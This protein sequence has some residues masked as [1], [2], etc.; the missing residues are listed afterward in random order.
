MKS[1]I[2]N[3]RGRLT[4][5]G[6]TSLAIVAISVGTMMS[7]ALFTDDAMLE[8]N[9]FTAGTIELSTTPASALFSVTSMMPGDVSYGQLTVSN[10]GSAELRYSMTSSSTDPDTKA[11]AAALNVEIRE[12]AAGTCSADFTGAVVLAST[13]LS[14]AAFGDA[15]AGQDTGDRV[16]A[17]STS[18]DV[19]F[20]VS[21]PG[22]AGDS[23][24][25]ATTTTTF[26][27]QAEQTANNS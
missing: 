13:P 27:F 21:L 9:T 2:G 19:C 23:Y 10:D 22:S 1:F 3:G 20:R 12:K 15:S 4:A 18:E 11:L 8:D 7:L 24:Q 14:S 25:G 17:V 5:L 26:T 6:L 16:L